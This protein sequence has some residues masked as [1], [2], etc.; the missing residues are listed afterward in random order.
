MKEDLHRKR[1][2]A[3]EQFRGILANIATKDR[4]CPVAMTK[5]QS[6]AF[7]SP[8]R[9]RAFPAKAVVISPWFES[10]VPLQFKRMN[11][12]PRTEACSQ[13]RS[14]DWR[15][16]GPP[17]ELMFNASEMRAAASGATV[18]RRR[19]GRWEV[20]RTWP[21]ELLAAREFEAV[22]RNDSSGT[23]RRL[24]QELP[25]VYS[26]VTARSRI[27]IADDDVL[28]R[29]SLAAVL[30]Y[31]GFTVDEAGDGSEAVARAT[32][33]P[34]DL[35]LLDLNMPGMDGWAAFN[36]LDHVRPLVPVI[37]ITAR[38]NQYPE[39]QRLGVDAFMEKPLNIPVLVR[40][41]RRLTSEG[42][43]RHVRRVTDPKFVTR[44]LDGSNS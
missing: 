36:K 26:E 13:P 2:P 25:E 37:I 33:H 34:P 9:S 8:G 21:G 10:D 12:R 40:A 6:T 4:G 3:R 31:E 43:S 23:S 35:V 22:V 42:E 7:H 24:V 14:P 5:N 16:A 32:A 44:L 19:D 18:I 15:L 29:G 38:P 41:I 17:P 39:A 27:L 28:V 30:E 20:S 1:K 11:G